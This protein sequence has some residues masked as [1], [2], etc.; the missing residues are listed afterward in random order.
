MST[1]WES[2]QRPLFVKSVWMNGYRHAVL[3]KEDPIGRPKTVTTR[4]HYKNTTSARSQSKTSSSESLVIP[5]VQLL[6]ADINRLKQDGLKT[7]CK[8]LIKSITLNVISREQ[9][10]N[11]NAPITVKNIVM[12]TK[13]SNN[14]N[15]NLQEPSHKIA[16]IER[17]GSLTERV[18]LW[19]DLAGRFTNDPQRNQDKYKQK[20]VRKEINRIST[21]HPVSSSSTTHN[22]EVVYVRNCSKNATP[23]VEGNTKVLQPAED[24]SIITSELEVV[25]NCTSAY[26]KSDSDLVVSVPS[27]DLSKRQVHIFMPVLEKKNNENIS[28]LSYNSTGSI[29][30]NSV[31]NQT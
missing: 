16:K 17:L 9:N 1:R 10:E 27:Q 13:H 14:Y 2:S 18:L 15:N 26:K 12:Q 25:S 29:S 7:P 4:L 24:A 23:F 19:L 31:M 20:N 11:T 5:A 30:L 8:K 21:A 3:S 22:T 28:V 6:I